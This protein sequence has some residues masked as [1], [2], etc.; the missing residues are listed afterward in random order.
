MNDLDDQLTPEETA[1]R[2]DEV[3]RRMLN[4][5]PHPHPGLKVVKRGLR[6]GQ[7]LFGTLPSLTFDL[8]CGFGFGK[9][10]RAI[11]Y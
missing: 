10:V 7:R 5:P 2:R 3:L 9:P 6:L 11:A 1:R 4:T 8:K